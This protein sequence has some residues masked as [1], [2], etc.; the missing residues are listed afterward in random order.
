MKTETYAYYK[1]ELLRSEARLKELEEKGIQALSR[2][3]I[4]IA[5]GGDAEQAL[6]TAKMLVGNHIRYFQ[7]KV[8]NTQRPLFEF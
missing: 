6:R 1:Q 8:S 4:E 2:Y 5:S 3:D 7:E